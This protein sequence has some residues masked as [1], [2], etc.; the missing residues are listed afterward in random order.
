MEPAASHEAPA[1]KTG[2]SFAAALHLQGE[3]VIKYATLQLIL[4]KFNFT[5]QH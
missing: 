2:F 1:G 5:H 3:A 4:L